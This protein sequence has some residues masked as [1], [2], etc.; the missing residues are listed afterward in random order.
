MDEREFLESVA[1]GTPEARE[2]RAQVI[3]DQHQDHKRYI[4]RYGDDVSEISNWPWGD[5][6]S[7]QNR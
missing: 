6:R 3:R 4:A 1:I 5:G 2:Q 7:H